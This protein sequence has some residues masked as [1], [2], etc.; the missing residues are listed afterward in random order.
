MFTDLK[1]GTANKYPELSM[2]GEFVRKAVH[3][4]LLDANQS[5]VRIIKICDQCNDDRNYDRGNSQ[6]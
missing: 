5:T 6:G 2:L 4:V 3:A 1:I